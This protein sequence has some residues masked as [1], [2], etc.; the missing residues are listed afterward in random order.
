MVKRDQDSL[1]ELVGG[2]VYSVWV[3]MLRRLVPEGRTHRL[4]PTI[5]SMLQYALGVADEK[6]GGDP[7]EGSL[8][9]LL[10]VLSEEVDDETKDLLLPTVE[11]L[12]E[13]SGVKAKRRSARGVE[14]S[15]AEAAIQEFVNWYNM[16]W[17]S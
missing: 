17:E 11:R 6:Y 5:A 7:E 16:P 12:L 14:Y 15:I 9:Y 10:F 8:A 3:D 13:D 1:K 2:K 4:A